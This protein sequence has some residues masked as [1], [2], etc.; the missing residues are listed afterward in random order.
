VLIILAVIWIILIVVFLVKILCGPKQGEE[1]SKLDKQV[2][3]SKEEEDKLKK[4]FDTKKEEIE[5]K[6]KELVLKRKQ[7]N[8]PEISSPS[9]SGPKELT[10]KKGDGLGAVDIG[11]I[12]VDFVEGNQS[13]DVID[14]E[15]KMD[16][17]NDQTPK[18]M[19]NGRT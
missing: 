8:L 19:S 1:K 15:N 6:R 7:L 2:K 14:N 4:E 5:K 10:A 17:P 13:S 16:A 9:K 12:Q 18:Y 11:E 3:E